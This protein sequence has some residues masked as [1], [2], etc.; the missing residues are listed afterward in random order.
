MKLELIIFGITGFLL[1]N[2][3]HDG[4]YT[5]VLYSYKK[6]YKMATIALVAISLYLLLKRNPDKS[7]QM[8]L[9]TNNLVKYMPIDKS[10]IDMISPIFDFTS[11]ADSSLMGALNGFKNNNSQMS[12]VLA[13]QQQRMTL[14]GQ[15]A[16]K[17]SVSETKKKYVASNQEWKCGHCNNKLTHT[18]EVDHKIRLEHGGGNDPSNLV[19]L[20]R[21]CHGQKTASE[22]M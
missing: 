4:K 10:T 19:A 2:A 14:S 3:Y 8:L 5:K 18:F 1:F 7:K 12:P 9:Y 13:A 22:N 16:T 20:C 21:E 15:K 11:K 17:R 6:Y